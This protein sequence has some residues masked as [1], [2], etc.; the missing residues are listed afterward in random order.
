[1]YGAKGTTFLN[2][3]ARQSA[4]S[5]QLTTVH[6]ANK[7][8]AFITTFP[9][10]SGKLYTTSR[11]LNNSDNNKDQPHLNGN[12]FAPLARASTSSQQ[13]TSTASQSLGRQQQLQF[14]SSAVAPKQQPELLVEEP[15]ARILELARF[16]QH[17]AVLEEFVALGKNLETPLNK[18]TYQAV[19]ESYGTLHKKNQPLTDMMGVYDEMV[20]HGIR[21][22]SETYA[23]VIRSLCARD[24]E[25]NRASN[26]IRRNMDTNMYSSGGT[27]VN[28]HPTSV[29]TL[30]KEGSSLNALE[31]EKNLQRA[32]A[33]FEQAVQENQTQAFDVDIYNN[34]LRGLSYIGNTQDGLFIYEQLENA[35]VRPNSTT[36]A[37]LVS[38]FGTAGDLKAV[39]ECFR[40]YKSIHRKLPH[41][42]VS[43]VY[44][45]LVFAYVNAG[46]LKGAL[47]IV[48][49]TMVK[50]KVPV[51][52]S[53]Y[54][55]IL[56]RASLDNNM[57][58]IAQLMAKLESSNSQLPKPDA[59]TYGV[60]LSSYCR[61]NNLDKAHEAYERLMSLSIE[62]QYGHLAEYVTVCLNN[63]QYDRSLDVVRAM[64]KQG[65]DLHVNLCCK[66]LSSYLEAGDIQKTM[67]TAKEIVKLH[68]KSTYFTANS[69]LAVMTLDIIKQSDNLKGALDLMQ[70]LAHYS[71]RSTKEVSQVMIQLYNQTKTDPLTWN[72]FMDNC[73]DRSFYIL[74]ESAFKRPCTDDDFS[75]TVFGLLHDMH[76]A[77]I[78]SNPS[79]F[80]RVGTR[81]NKRGRL[82]D[83][84][85]WKKTYEE[86]YPDVNKQVEEHQ[87]KSV[88][89]ATTTVNTKEAASAVDLS[90]TPSPTSTEARS[91]EALTIALHGDFNKA[92]ALMK[93]KIIDQG[94]VPTTEAVRDMISFSNKSN[95]LQTTSA[96]YNLTVGPF[97]QLLEPAQRDHAMYILNNNMLI[98]HARQ[99]DLG[100]AKKYYDKLRVDGHFPDADAYGCLLACT[101]NDTTDESLDAMV[102][103]EEAKKHKVRPTVY[104]YNVIISK[105]AKCRKMD[106]A[107]KLFT[108][109]NQLGVAPNSVT[110]ASVIS[111]C[112]RCSWEARAVHYFEEMLQMPR[113]Q[114]RIGVYN[115]MIQF[116]VQQRNDRSK[117][118]DYFQ[119]LKQ[120]NLVPSAHTYKLMI[121][122]YANIPAFDMVTAHGLLTEMKK[123]HNLNPTATHY[124]TLIKSY[125]CLHRDVT[126]A[127]AVYKEMS[128][129]RI[130]PNDLVYQALL[131][132]Y[133]GNDKMPQAE[134]LYKTML[135]D[136][137]VTSSPYIENLFI[138][139]YGEIG[140]V[141]K[142]A[143][144]FDRMQH[145][146]WSKNDVVR[147]PSTYEAMVKVYMNHDQ[148]DKAKAILEKM[149]SRD[150]PVKVVE[151]VALLVE[152][153]PE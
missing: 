65:V 124:A 119:K 52:I 135:L 130:R 149:E 115:S 92:L 24:A 96:I 83:E 32:V 152:R 128:K 111:A 148:V 89:A 136:A 108:E 50:D 19:M 56:Y 53:P 94:L 100:N 80:V 140:Q 99:M 102:I 90:S 118:L 59:N 18:Q 129:N 68:S 106:E 45:A 63:K 110:Y 112:I 145:E 84:A 117:A 43:Y 103:Y 21:P 69:P 28:L 114:P 153:G 73:T 42:D 38:M 98:A 107:L 141:E 12:P 20:N 36:F 126:S 122:A 41:H 37:M 55:K 93:E 78:G 29:E 87:Q 48:E 70:V 109:M 16:K 77:G 57:E 138:K 49:E 30:A 131:D 54:N 27:A 79:V 121:E 46:D 142:A 67:V 88:S 60:L 81:L 6:A 23:I 113:Y 5:K 95:L 4:L 33:V 125:G 71:I 143:E 82:E 14:D 86:Y 127:E 10:R 8:S 75:K 97:S 61:S 132:T 72:Q 150:F 1:M 144:V 147:E 64:C 66:V 22:T 7:T 139:G 26:V 39:R 123:R 13:W 25:V 137:K 120:A 9:A 40:E 85:L 62:R 151:G 74:Y 47:R 31:S 58:L 11:T 116:Y 44:N 76:A 104:F 35:H 51:T 91:A 3:V 146:Q 105:M 17:G 2:T 34:L 15:N 101:A 133:I 134:D